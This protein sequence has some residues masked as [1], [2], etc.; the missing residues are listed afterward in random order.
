MSYRPR[1][2]RVALSTA[3]TVAPAMVAAAFV[4]GGPAAQAADTVPIPLV[5]GSFDTAWTPSG[6]SCWAIL[7]DGAGASALT[8]STPGTSGARSAKLRVTRLAATGSRTL[9]TSRELRCAPPAEAGDRI[10]VTA[11]Y[12]GT[13]ATR[14]VL[15]YRT[16]SGWHY[17]ARSP[18]FAARGTWGRAAW[19]T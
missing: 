19:T 10:S 8:A 14:W 7:R 16:S 5:N 11:A 13:R 12:A 18:L 2:G 17:L 4:V 3:L 1:L 15:R 9:A 6:P